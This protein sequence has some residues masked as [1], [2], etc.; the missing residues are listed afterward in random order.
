MSTITLGKTYYFNNR[1][2][3]PLAHEHGGIYKCFVHLKPDHDV[4]G[5]MFCTKCMA[6]PP[7]VII[8][9]T[10]DMAQEVIDEVMDGIADE[11]IMWIPQRYLMDQPFEYA[12]NEK[13]KAEG[14]RLKKSIQSEKVAYDKIWNERRALQSKADAA[15]KAAEES[16]IKHTKLYEKYDAANENLETKLAEVSDVSVIGVGQ[17]SSKDFQ[18]IYLNHL[19]FLD[20]DAGGVDNWTWY[21]ESMRDHTKHMIDLADFYRSARS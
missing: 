9:H 13:L 2:I 20:L 12:V 18:E 6:A 8:S 16:I 19:R 5:S 10:C 7:G 1:P 4:T 17:I 3:V 14:E 11:D 15:K 21:G